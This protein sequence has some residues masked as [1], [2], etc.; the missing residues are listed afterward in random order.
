MDITEL[1]KTRRSIRRF[2]QD[3]I[4]EKVLLELIESARCAPSAGNKQ[5]LEYVI[6][7]NIPLIGEV[8]NQLKWAA[9]VTPKRNPPVGMRPVAYI[10]V[11]IN[12]D[13]QLGDIGPVDAAAA[14]ENILLTAWSKQ[15]GTC[16]IGSIDRPNLCKILSLPDNIKIDSIIAL[17][18]PAE[19]PVLED[20]KTDSVKYYLDD[21]DTL[22]VPKRKLTDVTHFNKY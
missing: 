5:P 14:I 7:N 2:K 8:F 19:T 9:F 11:L 16:W 18:R 15:I 21:S 20:I 3:P 1:I 22:H 6:I 12:T 17:G 13:R 10:A 4:D